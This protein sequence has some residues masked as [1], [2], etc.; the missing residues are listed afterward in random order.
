M[1]SN[2][3]FTHGASAEMLNKQ[4]TNCHTTLNIRKACCRGAVRVCKICRPAPT[5]LMVNFSKNCAFF[6]LYPYLLRHASSC[7]MQCLTTLTKPFKHF[8]LHDAM[9]LQ[10]GGQLEMFSF[11]L[12]AQIT[13]FAVF[14]DVHTLSSNN[15]SSLLKACKNQS[16]HQ[17]FFKFRSKTAPPPLTIINELKLSSHPCSPLGMAL[18]S[19]TLYFVKKHEHA[20]FTRRGYAGLCREA[21][22]DAGPS[23][24]H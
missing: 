23:L 19:E 16:A 2:G 3:N 21:V 15:Y 13:S 9:K 8:M 18:C 24:L 6:S 22:S 20:L 11:L 10:K 1:K 5:V 4:H 7:G 12:S 17:T 14:E